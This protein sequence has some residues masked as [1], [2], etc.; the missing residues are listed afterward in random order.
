MAPV[1][2]RGAQAQ[3][4]QRLDDKTALVL[5]GRKRTEAIALCAAQKRRT[6]DRP[7]AKIEAPDRHHTGL[8]IRNQTGS[9][10]L[11]LFFKEADRLELG[12]LPLYKVW[13]Q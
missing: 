10:P 6:G 8:V 2:L 9:Y 12:R 5:L 4:W 1:E 7:G 11:A 13:W 3:K